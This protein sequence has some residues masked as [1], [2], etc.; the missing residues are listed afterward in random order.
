MT[1]D[2]SK[3]VLTT[4]REHWEYLLSEGICD[5][6]EGKKAIG[7]FTMA[8]ASLEAWEKVKADIIAE[9]DN[10]SNNMQFNLGL[11]AAL[12]IINKHLQERGDKE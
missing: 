10:K 3:T 9:S 11:L 1:I 8:I 6:H 4:H 7:A 5:A 2:E 12:A